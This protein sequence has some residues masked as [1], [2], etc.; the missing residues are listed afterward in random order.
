M[1]NEQRDI[2]LTGPPRSGTTL[3][4]L[5]LNKLT[6]VV[7]LH[8]P[9]NLK[10][11]ESKTAAMENIPNFFKEM[12]IMITQEG[13]AIS[14]I[15]DGKIPDNP[16]PSGKSNRQSIVQ[17]GTFKLVRPPK[18]KN[19]SLVIKHNAHF[20]FLLDQLKEKYE[21]F[22]VV[23]NPLAVLSSW[24]TIKAP[25]SQGNLKVLKTLDPFLEQ[26]LWSIDDLYERQITLL[27]LLFKE[28][29]ILDR[30]KII[31]YE[32][33]IES[34]GRALSPISNK[35]LNLNESLQNTNLEK[36]Y[37]L[38]LIDHIYQKLIKKPHYWSEFYASADI[39]E[40]MNTYL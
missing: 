1:I 7:A 24:N 37:P 34:G 11:F 18:D 2:I 3:S 28:L 21:C 32:D 15:K 40:V 31:K 39:D 4:C 36:R 17:K 12:R 29:K 14:R 13:K 5:L 23:R 10:T 20:T 26:K 6:G 19:F 38:S 8:E 35:A 9:M 22:A 33:I 16:F 27:N 25:V 30:S